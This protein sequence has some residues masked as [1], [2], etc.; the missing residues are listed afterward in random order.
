MIKRDIPTLAAI[1]FTALMTL[2]WFVLFIVL[3]D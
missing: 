2:V 3:P 1:A